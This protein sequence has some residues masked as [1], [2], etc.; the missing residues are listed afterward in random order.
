MATKPKIISLSLIISMKYCLVLGDRNRRDVINSDDYLSEPGVAFCTA[1]LKKASLKKSKEPLKTTLALF[2]AWRPAISRVFLP[3]AWGY[4]RANTKNK[5]NIL[6]GYIS[7]WIK[8][9]KS[10]IWCYVQCSYLRDGSV[11][12]KGI[13]GRRAGKDVQD[14][15]VFWVGHHAERAGWFRISWTILNRWH[16]KCCWKVSPTAN[17]RKDSVKN[18]PQEVME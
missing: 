1:E 12:E 9:L 18:R 8:W 2:R 16:I 13:G 4:W 17:Y 6:C 7:F 11:R 14:K 5:I 15:R 3:T 10:I